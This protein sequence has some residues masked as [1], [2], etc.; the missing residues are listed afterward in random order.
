[1]KMTS[2]VTLALLAFSLAAFT[3]QAQDNGGPPDGGPDGGPPQ[4]HGFHRPPPLPLLLALDTNHDG[5]IDSNEIAN[6]R[7]DLFT[8]YKHG[9]GQLTTN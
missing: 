5:I 6:G 7:V 4:G 9:D 8:L 3:V 2:K 1:M